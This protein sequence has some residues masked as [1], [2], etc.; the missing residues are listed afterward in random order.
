MQKLLLYACTAGF[1][2]TCSAQAA[3]F[4]DQANGFSV[5][6]PAGW[7]QVQP[8]P[9][10]AAVL[11]KAPT[12]VGGFTSNINVVKEDLASTV[13]LQQYA[14]QSAANFVKALGAKLA[15]SYEGTM[16]G[17]P[18]VSQVFTATVQGK[19]LIFSQAFTVVGKRAYV[20]TATTLTAQA[21][22]VAPL[23]SDFIKSFKLVK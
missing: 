11:F 5:T 3:T 21:Q 20:V 19:P 9:Q 4:T 12:T 22:G 23:F 1:I 13:S 8:T 10:G 16:G 17:N 18:A 7:T 15:N 6:P 14:K 2:L